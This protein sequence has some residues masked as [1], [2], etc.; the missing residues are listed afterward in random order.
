MGNHISPDQLDEVTPIRRHGASVTMPAWAWRLV[1]IA[2]L[3]MFAGAIATGVLLVKD[4][5]ETRRLVYEHENQKDSLKLAQAQA[6]LDH[7][8]RL[9]N[10]ENDNSDFL[11]AFNRL[12]SDIQEMKRDI[13]VIKSRMP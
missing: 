6:A 13:A 4:Y 11:S 2:L 10:L 8:K 3:L 1:T 5:L 9:A 12:Q 7:E